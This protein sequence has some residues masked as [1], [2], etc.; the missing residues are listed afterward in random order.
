MLW[1]S[2]KSPWVQDAHL[3]LCFCL[4]YSPFI[5]FYFS[6][7]GSSRIT[8]SISSSYTHT[9]KIWQRHSRLSRLSKFRPQPL[10]NL[11]DNNC[12]CYFFELCLPFN[13]NVKK[14]KTCP[15]ITGV[16]GSATDS[17]SHSQACVQQ[18]TS[19]QRD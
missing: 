8:Q 9:A 11:N 12:S 18:H 1:R 10:H 3:L 5:Y 2:L 7:N 19:V 4:R 17:P 16:T 13:S 6:R 15:G 14:C